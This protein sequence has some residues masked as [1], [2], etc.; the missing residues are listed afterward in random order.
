MLVEKQPVNGMKV[1]RSSDHLTS[2]IWTLCGALLSCFG[3]FCISRLEV[4]ED[5]FLFGEAQSRVVVSVNEDQED[6]FIE[7]MMEQSVPYTLLGHVTKGKM[8]VDD[9]QYAFVDEIKSI[10]DNALEEALA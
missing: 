6:E 3:Y 4:R 2:F 8:C 10:Y 5:A 1:F 7:F 9:E